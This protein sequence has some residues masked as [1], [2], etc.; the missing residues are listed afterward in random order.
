MRSTQIL[1]AMK[2][3]MTVSR[4]QLVKLRENTEPILTM[5]FFVSK[6]FL[7]NFFKCTRKKLKIIQKKKQNTD[8]YPIIAF[9]LLQDKM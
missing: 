9:K 4:H 5:R 7:K 2:F 6:I 1:I 3:D 8:F